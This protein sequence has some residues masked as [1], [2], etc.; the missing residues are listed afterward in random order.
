V[1]ELHFDSSLY[2][3][4]AIDAATKVYAE[5]ARFERELVGGA[6]VVRFEATGDF[7][8]A[9]IADE[10]MNYALGA[11]IEARQEDGQGS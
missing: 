1:T 6:F 5:Y 10:L 7:D 9:A 4:N 3:G 11:T 2:S 8:E